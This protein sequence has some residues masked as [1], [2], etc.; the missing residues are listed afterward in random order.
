MNEW[1]PFVEVKSVVGPDGTVKDAGWRGERVYVNEFYQ[2]N[3]TTMETDDGRQDMSGLVWLS[4][5]R[6]D[7]TA[8]HDWRHFQRIKDELAGPERWGVEVFPPESKLVDTSDQ[9]H[10]W[11]MPESV[12]FPAFCFQDR[13]VADRSTEVFGG[14]QRS[15][16]SSVVPPDSTDPKELARLMGEYG[17]H[18]N[19]PEDV[20]LTRAERRRQRR[21]M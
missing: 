18:V 19:Y 3:V 6:R 15:F 11:V 9:Y 16:A 1:T 8:T 5:K 7:R 10:I 21:S 2:V 12:D 4:I 20:P 14:S 13:I 17:V